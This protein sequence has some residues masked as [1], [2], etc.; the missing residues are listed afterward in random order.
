MTPIQ[1][2]DGWSATKIGVPILVLSGTPTHADFD[3]DALKDISLPSNPPPKYSAC[4]VHPSVFGLYYPGAAPWV[5][6]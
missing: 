6:V 5:P 2:S 4:T 1:A 3:P